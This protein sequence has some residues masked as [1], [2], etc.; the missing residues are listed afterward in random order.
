MAKN[1][2]FVSAHFLCVHSFIFSLDVEGGLPFMQDVA[3]RPSAA[4][5]ST[6][7]VLLHFHFVLRGGGGPQPGGEDQAGPAPA[8]GPPRL[9]P[10]AAGGLPGWRVAGTGGGGGGEGGQCVGIVLVVVVVAVLVCL[11]F[12][13]VFMST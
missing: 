5:L 4:G 6:P 7:V 9:C 3:N 12:L 8:A 13:V 1:F 11:F 2:D 10:R